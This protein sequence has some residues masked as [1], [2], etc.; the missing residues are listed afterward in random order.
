MEPEPWG[1]GRSRRVGVG[2]ASSLV[3]P[4]V[5]KREMRPRVEADG[6]GGSIP[7]AF[8]PVP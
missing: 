1:V 4:H 8:L 3:V 7:P 5:R 6:V 2:K